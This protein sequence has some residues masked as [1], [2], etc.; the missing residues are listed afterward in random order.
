MQ[1]TLPKNSAS[2][3]TQI[4][5]APKTSMRNLIKS[6]EYSGYDCIWFAQ[7]KQRI[8]IDVLQLDVAAL[9]VYIVDGGQ[10]TSKKATGLLNNGIDV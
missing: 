9:T 3:I 8:E 6:F 1:F 2:E 4:A 7:I 5:S 10:D